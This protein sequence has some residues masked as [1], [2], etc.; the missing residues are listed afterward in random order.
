MS[1][2]QHHR[3]LHVRIEPHRW[4]ILHRRFLTPQQRY[5]PPRLNIRSK[6]ILPIVIQLNDVLALHEISHAPVLVDP[7][8]QEP[9]TWS[10][11]VFLRDQHEV[12]LVLINLQGAEIGKAENAR[13]AEGSEQKVI[14]VFQ[15]VVVEGKFM[16]V[17]ESVGVV[18]QGF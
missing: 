9:T 6:L 10:T 18:A 3:L 15:K 16:H 4:I 13:D 17:V 5:G 8:H 14:E 7:S 2:C 1:L 11:T 12:K